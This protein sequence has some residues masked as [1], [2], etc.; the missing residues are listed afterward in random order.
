LNWATAA[1]AAIDGGDGG[2]PTAKRT[3]GFL[4]CAH[5][6]ND[7]KPMQ[8]ITSKMHDV[9]LKICLKLLLGFLESQRYAKLKDR[10]CHFLGNKRTLL[11]NCRGNALN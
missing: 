7:A 2:H 6:S 4:C 1:A 3:H 5:Q 10:L 11:L 9:L 8:R